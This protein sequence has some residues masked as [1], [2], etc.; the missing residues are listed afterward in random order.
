MSRVTQKLGTKGSQKWLQTLINQHPNVITDAFQQAANLPSTVGVEWCSP[1]KNDD[2]AEYRDHS[3]VKHLDVE[4][5]Q[6]T[7]ASFWPS[8]GP[9]WDG[10]GR[11]IESHLLLIEAKS[12]IT[13]ISPSGTKARAES[14]KALIKASLDEAKKFYGSS[15]EADWSH[16]YYQYTNRLAHLYL[17][18]QLNALPAFLVNVYFVNDEEMGGPT[19]REEWQEGLKRIKTVLGIGPHALDK[20]AVDLFFDVTTL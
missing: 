8:G 18:R 16:T 10:L 1:L 3:F 9:V 20:Y 14:S 15:A 17:L 13:E 5:T 6:R 12:H 2:Y 7:L 4:L 11:S 19:S